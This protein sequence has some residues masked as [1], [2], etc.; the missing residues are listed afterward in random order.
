MADDSLIAWPDVQ[1]RIKA[2][3]R[4]A[5]YRLAQELGM[6]SSYLY[7][8]LK[9][10]DALTV[11]QARAIQAFLDELPA[12][13][14]DA[15]PHDAALIPVFG[16]AAMGGADLIALNEGQ[17]VEWMRL[18]MGLEVGPGEWFIVKGIGSSMEPRIFAGDHLLIRRKHPPAYGKDVL[19]EFN[20]GSGLIKTYRGERQGRVFAEQWNERK[21]VD[22]DGASVKA[23][24]GS[25]IKL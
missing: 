9:S 11:G 15:P 4:G 21:M 17:I 3:P 10:L 13:T 25:V 7:R 2:L 23:L 19:I 24:H 14:T 6:N 5:P 8:K 22:Y 16:Y 12:E 1:R 20:D 18:P